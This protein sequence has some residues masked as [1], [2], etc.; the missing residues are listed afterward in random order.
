MTIPKSLEVSQQ[1][2]ESRHERAGNKKALHPLF[3]HLEQALAGRQNPR[4]TV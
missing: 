4:G 3:R 1:T 2:G